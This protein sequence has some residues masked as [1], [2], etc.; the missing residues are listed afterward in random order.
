VNLS[1]ITIPIKLA[2]YPVIQRLTENLEFHTLRKVK[3]IICIAQTKIIEFEHFNHSKKQ[4]LDKLDKKL[5]NIEY[6]MKLISD[7]KAYKTKMLTEEFE[8]EYDDILLKIENELFGLEENSDGIY[9]KEAFSYLDSIVSSYEKVA[10]EFFQSREQFQPRFTIKILNIVDEGDSPELIVDDYF[11]KDSMYSKPN[12][13]RQFSPMDN[14]A[15]K[16]L[17]EDLEKE[18]YLENDIPKAVTENKYINPRIDIEKAKK[19]KQSFKY[20]WKFIRNM[21]GKDPDQKW[22]DVWKRPENKNLQDSSCYKST[23]VVPI[24]FIRNNFSNH[25][26][27]EKVNNTD[28]LPLGFVCLDSVYINYFRQGDIKLAYMLADLFSISWQEFM[29]F[30]ENISNESI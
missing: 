19:Y 22:Q 10:L 20:N 16:E 13:K 4:Y 27:K 12:W 17:I 11:R 23:L 21:F 1:F 25:E 24:T 14:S 30:E 8:V 28:L 9:A 7:S 3:E 6:K 15:F 26:I 29:L 5:D 2:S 18:N